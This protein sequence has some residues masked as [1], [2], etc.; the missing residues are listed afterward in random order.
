MVCP[1]TRRYHDDNDAKI[2]DIDVIAVKKINS[3]AGV[4][5]VGSKYAQSALPRT[6]GA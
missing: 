2:K 6:N 1:I 5:V 4:V 3:F